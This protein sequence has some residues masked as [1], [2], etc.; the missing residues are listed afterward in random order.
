MLRR[1]IVLIET[2][3]YILQSSRGAICL[4]FFRGT[5]VGDSCLDSHQSTPL[6]L[7]S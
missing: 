2:L 7:G 1:S 3:K 6:V 4:P 5:K